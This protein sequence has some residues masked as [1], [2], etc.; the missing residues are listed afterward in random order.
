MLTF[1]EIASNIAELKQRVAD[2]TA[3]CGRSDEIKIVAATKTQPKEL[4]DFIAQ[5]RLLT[6]VG[7]NRVQELLTKY[8]PESSLNWHLIGQLQSN[9]VKY[10][11]DK[12]VLI[13]SLDR[14]ELADEIEKRAEKCGV[15]QDCLVEVNMGSEISKGGVEPDSAVEFVKSLAGYGHIRV[16]GLMSVLPA[17]GDTPELRRLYAELQALY[18]EACGIKQNNAKIDLLSAG[19]TNDYHVALEYGANIIR[20]GRAI[21]G[22]RIYPATAI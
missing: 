19:M 13:H 1:E 20:V 22:E 10:I 18:G 2:V 21:F 7:E 3:K 11:I 15:V 5:N 9:K 14:T 16:R 4:I 8:T 17:L 12:V 6:D